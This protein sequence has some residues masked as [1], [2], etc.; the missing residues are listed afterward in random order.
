VF[1]T[2]LNAA[3]SAPLLYSTYLG[4]SSTDIGQGIALDSAGSAYVTGY[5]CSGDFPSTVGAFDM[6]L[7]G[8]CDVFVTKLNAAG[9]APLLYSTY[10]GGSSTDIGQ[11]I[12]VDSAGSAY[13]SGYTSSGDFPTTPAAFDTTY[14]GNTDAF[15]TKLDAIGAPA[16]L[17]LSP[18]TATN[19][20]GTSHTVTAT[21]TDVAGQRVPGVVV[22]FSVT[23][24]HTVTGSCTT[25]PN[26]QCSFSYMGANPGI[27]TIDAYADSDNDS[28]RD[29][30]EPT[31]APV[32]KTWILS[33]AC[34]P[35]DDDEDDDGLEDRDERLLFLTLLGDRDSDDDGRRDGD[36]DSDDDGRDDEDEDDGTDDECPNDS[37]GDGEDDEDEDDDDEEDD[38]DD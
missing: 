22:R 23:G 38:E 4:G 26:G 2:K 7:N 9:S 15:V 8:G 32:T 10:L 13:V 12:A 35:G 20:T 14:N 33:P 25:G 37:D 31:G 28:M 5:T 3:G 29:P 34:P 6:T 11:G 36:D 1:V 17:T 30:G 16:T 24:V 21:V 19:P 18:A 27:D